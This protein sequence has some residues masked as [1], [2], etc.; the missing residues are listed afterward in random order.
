MHQRHTRTSR[1]PWT[2][3]SPAAT[4]GRRSGVCPATTPTEWK[5]CAAARLRPDATLRPLLSAVVSFEL[6]PTAD[7]EAAGRRPARVRARGGG[8]GRGRSRGRGRGGGRG[9]RGREGRVS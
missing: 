5:G 1:A 8:G 6:R 9:G 3:C 7:L 2:P 4:P